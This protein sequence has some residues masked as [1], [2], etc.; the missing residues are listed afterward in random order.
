MDGRQITDALRRWTACQNE[1]T[2]VVQSYLE[3]SLE[4]HKLCMSSSN[5]SSSSAES[6]SSQLDRSLSGLALLEDALYDTRWVL[7][8]ASC[9]LARG[10]PIDRLP[11]EVLSTI[12]IFGLEQEAISAVQMEEG[13]EYVFQTPGSLAFLKTISRICRRWRNVA[14]DTGTLWTSIDVS[15]FV[16]IERINAFSQRS[17]LCP[18]KIHFEFHP[19]QNEHLDKVIV[20]L[21]THAPRCTTLS[22]TVSKY[23]LD[24]ILQSLLSCKDPAFWRIHTLY[25]VSFIDIEGEDGQHIDT[26]V[27]PQANA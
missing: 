26:I 5:L 19:D 13:H 11:D 6:L 4:L 24:R 22:L 3:A 18:L 7:Q 10:N 1:A 8:N 20:W 21:Q 16:P 17:K 2:S 27:T 14:L 23:A 15:C 9:R 25:A 12:F